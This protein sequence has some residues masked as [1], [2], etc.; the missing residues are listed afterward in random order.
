M[1]MSL[2]ERCYEQTSFILQ[3][4]VHSDLHIDVNEM[5]HLLVDEREQG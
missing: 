4:S 2:D 1:Y 3:Q 5:M